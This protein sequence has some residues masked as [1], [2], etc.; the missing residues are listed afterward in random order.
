MK[1]RKRIYKKKPKANPQKEP[2]KPTQKPPQTQS[3]HYITVT[4]P[5][6][7]RDGPGA[8]P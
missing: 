8:I 2:H 3:D 5:L 1:K 4:L 6:I 7:V